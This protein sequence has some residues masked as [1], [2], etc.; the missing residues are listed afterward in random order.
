MAMSDSLADMRGLAERLA[1]RAAEVSSAHL[2]RVA[3]RRKADASEVTDVDVAIESLILDALAAQYPDH[4]VL[5]EEGS[6]RPGRH[7]PVESAEFCWVIDPLDGTRNFVREF[8]IFST[9]IA[10]LRAGRPVVGVIHSHT[11]GQTFSAIDDGQSLL[12]SR[13][14]QVSDEPPGHNTIIAVPTGRRLPAAP[15]VKAWIDRYVLRNIGSTALHMALVA[16]GALDAAFCE[17]CKVW[18]VAAGALL[19]ERAG[20]I[21]TDLA[22]R[23]L[24]PAAFAREA[25]TDVPFLC[26][27]PAVH[28]ALLH[29]I[30]SEMRKR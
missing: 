1:V 5:T 22:G 10:V 3:V 6:A 21:C 20:G 12:D 18:D 17:E 29:D 16:S 26:A 13:P 15:V 9:S 28:T 24:F 14:A 19:V 2:G 7:G 30:E 25:G 8:P 27:S 23:P 4:A 11:T